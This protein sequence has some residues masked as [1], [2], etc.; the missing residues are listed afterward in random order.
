MYM[1][2]LSIELLESEIS[3]ANE[4]SDFQGAFES[5]QIASDWLKA[6]KISK[7]SAEYA[8]YLECLTKLKLICLNYFDNPDDYVDILKNHFSLSF[9]IPNFNLWGKLETELVYISDLD[10]RDKI[11]K[12]FK[13]AL[14][15]CENTLTS[16]YSEPN[17]PRK[18]NEWIKNFIANLG[19]DKFDTVKK[20]EYISNGQFIK[21]LK[22]E[23]KKKVLVLMDIYEKLSLSS[24]T[25]EGYENSVLMDIDGKKV[26]YNRG[27]IEEVNKFDNLVDFEAA[28][29]PKNTPIATPSANQPAKSAV[30]PNNQTLPTN[31]IV[32]PKVE[33]PSGSSEL[34]QALKNYSPSSLEYKAIKQEIER[35]N[36]ADKT[37]KPK[38][39]VKK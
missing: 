1:P 14:E 34:E 19:L 23:D 27:T 31:Q 39:D 26:I 4:N 32:S 33:M 7:N 13:E 24:R 10:E 37:A 38:L 11:K 6:Q 29:Q 2:E 28:P 22:E 5:Y 30:E 3:Y 9:Q 17:M 18:V 25:K 15:K 21:N 16:G 20:V 35:Q 8:K 12:Q 36:K